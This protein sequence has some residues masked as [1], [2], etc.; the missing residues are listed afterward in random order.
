MSVHAVEINP[1]APASGP[2]SASAIQLSITFKG[3]NLVLCLFPLSPAGVSE[4]PLAQVNFSVDEHFVVL[5]LLIFSFL[6]LSSTF[7]H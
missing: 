3:N 5:T 6:L 2:Q 7:T 1:S 4:L